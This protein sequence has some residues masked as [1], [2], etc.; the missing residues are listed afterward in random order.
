MPKLIRCPDGHVFDS[1]AHAA[2]PHCSPSA[3]ST[4][5]SPTEP[6]SA[7]VAASQAVAPTSTVVVPV[8]WLIGGVA[9]LAAAA[10]AILVLAW[11]APDTTK[12]APRLA[13]KDP[14]AET[15]VVPA[16]P[17]PADPQVQP[18]PGPL[19]PP[20]PLPQPQQQALPTPQPPAPPVP[21][22]KPSPNNVVPTALGTNHAD[23]LTDWG[24][25]PQLCFRT[26][27]AAAR[28]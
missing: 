9:I 27:S 5:G 15:K 19:I 12:T 28:R 17:K 18:L 4:D 21:D 7:A 23:E 26:I 11:P 20:P 10:G 14:P 16:Q 22:V 1:E 8:K 25:P 3:A 2:C 6:A 24:S 13:A